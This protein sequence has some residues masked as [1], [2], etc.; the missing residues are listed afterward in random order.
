MTNLW[1][2]KLRFLTNQ[3]CTNVG[4][5]RTANESREGRDERKES[6]EDGEECNGREAAKAAQSSRVPTG[7]P[8]NVILMVLS[9][10]GSPTEHC[11]P[12]ACGKYYVDA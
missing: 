3:R 2:S 5:Q 9:S 10:A 8:E 6:G 11:R 4:P 1:I 12:M 7:D